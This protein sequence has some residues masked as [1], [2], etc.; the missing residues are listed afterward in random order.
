MAMI[1]SAEF[2]EGVEE[3]IVAVTPG[4]GTNPRIEKASTSASKRCWSL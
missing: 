3:V 2:G 4:E 1:G